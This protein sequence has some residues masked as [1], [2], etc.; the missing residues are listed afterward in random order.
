M[1]RRL[2]EKRRGGRGG[3]AS[4]VLLMAVLCLL[5]SASKSLAS[6]TLQG[7]ATLVGS[8]VQLTQAVGNSDGAAWFDSQ[9]NLAQDF[10]VTYT[11]RFSNG[12]NDPGAD[13]ICFVLQRDARGAGAVGDT[14]GGGEYI[15][16]HS[17][18]PA[19]AIEM[20]T[21]QN[22]VQGDPAADQIQELGQR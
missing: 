20:D 17:I 2:G 3:R 1:K 14:L 8:Q 12:T 22:A 21:Y 6:W 10:D 9:I 5:A 4:I 15:G 7:T 18:M 11:M 16:M 19:I 13:G